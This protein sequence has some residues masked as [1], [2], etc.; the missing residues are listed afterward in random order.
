MLRQQLRPLPV[1]V[2]A[3][4]PRPTGRLPDYGCRSADGYAENWRLLP[5]GLQMPTDDGWPVGFAGDEGDAGATGVA[6]EAGGCESGPPE[7]DGGA[8]VSFGRYGDWLTG[9]RRRQLR[10]PDGGDGGGGCAAAGAEAGANADAGVAGLGRC[11]AGLPRAGA[12]RPP[13][14]PQPC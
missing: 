14:L 7:P 8:Y 6:Q 13:Q 9:E 12:R 11:E 4:P 1:A 3:E 5:V 10:R 2:V